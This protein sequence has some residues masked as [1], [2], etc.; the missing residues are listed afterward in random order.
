[1][2][3]QTRVVASQILCPTLRGSYGDARAEVLVSVASLSSGMD[4]FL[5]PERRVYTIHSITVSIHEIGL[6]SY[7]VEWVHP[8]AALDVS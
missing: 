5:Q 8:V 7:V 1:M 2:V 6:Q 3:A 4:P